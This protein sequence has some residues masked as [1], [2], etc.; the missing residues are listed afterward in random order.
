[1]KENYSVSKGHGIK[2]GSSVTRDFFLHLPI[3]K[4]SGKT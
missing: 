4:Y 3:I 1:M 2:Q